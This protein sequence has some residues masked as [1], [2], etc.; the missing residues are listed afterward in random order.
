MTASSVT[1][2]GLGNASNK[3]HGPMIVGAGQVI[4]DD[5]GNATVITPMYSGSV[6]DYIII[7]T[8]TGD[9]RWPTV[10]DTLS[11]SGNNWTFSINDGAD[12]STTVY[13][14]IVRKGTI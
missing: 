2:V 5:S 4:T 9:Q 14:M 10:I 8:A 12:N 7:L 13:W 6:N 11:V 1:G 3:V